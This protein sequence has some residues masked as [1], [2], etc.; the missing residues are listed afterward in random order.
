MGTVNAAA[1]A[2]ATAA[3]AEREA[4]WAR[5]EAILAEKARVAGLLAELGYEVIPSETNFLLVAPPEGNGAMADQLADYLFDEAGIIVNQA[6]E[7]GL[8]RFIRFSLSLPE[9]NS[10]LVDCVRRFLV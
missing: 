4:M 1:Q 7:A 2:G 8:E 6:R 9:H 10:A 3:L 5:V